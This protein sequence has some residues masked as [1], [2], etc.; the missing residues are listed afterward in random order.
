MGGSQESERWRLEELTVNYRTPGRIATAAQTMALA[1]G[2]PVTLATSVREGEWPIEVV[3]SFI[4]AVRS[5]RADSTGGT[6]AVIALPEAIDSVIEVLTGEFDV[7]RGASNLTNEI[8]VLSP[9]DAKGL[10]FDSVVVVE[11]RDILES[12]DRGA[13]ALF[14]AMTR[15]TQRLTLVTEGPLP[16][17]LGALDSS[18]S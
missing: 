7:G 1:H 8:S 13:S 3:P 12:S 15:P 5:D 16:E 17:G 14:V 11:P 2:L 10:E 6:L 18:A 9:R 4:E